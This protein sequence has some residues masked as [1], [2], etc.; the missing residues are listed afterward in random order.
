M[1]YRQ[2]PV[3]YLQKMELYPRAESYLE[4]TTNMSS[5]WS[6]QMPREVI[7]NSAKFSG[8]FIHVINKKQDIILLSDMVLKS[9]LL[10]FPMLSLHRVVIGSLNCP[11]HFNSLSTYWVPGFAWFLTQ[12]SWNDRYSWSILNHPDFLNSS[13]LTHG[14]L[15]ILKGGSQNKTFVVR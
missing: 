4:W 13:S 14:W 12:S 6:H 8:C 2:P 9:L 3:K 10:F 7:I 5:L 1:N 11:L 15:L